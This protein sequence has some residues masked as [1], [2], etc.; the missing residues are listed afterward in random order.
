MIPQIK[1]K[2]IIITF[3][4]NILF[5]IQKAVQKGIFSFYIIFIYIYFIMIYILYILNYIY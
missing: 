4:T 1:K 5:L 2:E 3:Y